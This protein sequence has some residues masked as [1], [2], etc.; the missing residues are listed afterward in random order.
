MCV[1]ETVYAMQETEAKNHNQLLKVL[2][3]DRF[4]LPMKFHVPEPEVR[5]LAVLDSCVSDAFFQIAANNGKKMKKKSLAERTKNKYNKAGKGPLMLPPSVRTCRRAHCC[6][7]WNYGRNR[8]P[9]GFRRSNSG[10]SRIG[11]S[12]RCLLELMLMELTP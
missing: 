11:C 10:W 8:C 1:S 12:D 3:D 9:K 7:H 2:V 6:A 5:E 4:S